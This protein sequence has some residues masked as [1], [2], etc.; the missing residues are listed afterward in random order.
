M[1][2]LV[3]LNVFIHVGVCVQM[4]PATGQ[5]LPL[6]SY[7]GTSMVVSLFACGVLLGL[8][9]RKPAGGEPE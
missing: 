5:P 8:S 3:A 7:G 1:T 4:G 6:I 2:M 9:R